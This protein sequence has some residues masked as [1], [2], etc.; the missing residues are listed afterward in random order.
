MSAP[1]DAAR[2]LD[3]PHPAGRLVGVA[4]SVQRGVQGHRQPGR[5]IVGA[6]PT[7]PPSG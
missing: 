6:I 1:R 2:E 4:A 7:T 5:E 3:R